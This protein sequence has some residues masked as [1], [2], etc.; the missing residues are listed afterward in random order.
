VTAFTARTFDDLA[1]GDSWTSS[2]R[3]IT[4][5]DIVMF[6]AYSG[7]YH[8]LH[9]DDEYA[10]STEFGG[11][12][13]HGIAALVIA[14]GLDARLAITDEA[15]ITFLGFTWDFREPIRIGDTIR[16]R[17]TVAALRPSRSKPDRGI[18]TFDAEVLNQHDVVC[19]EGK[20]KLMMRR[21]D[22]GPAARA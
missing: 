7:D 4:D 10:R 5:A 22:A 20:W 1:V 8:P 18:V 19:Q 3:T 6:A 12:V 16:A 17:R 21:R 9:V 2:G 14:I 15:A 13:L 11:R